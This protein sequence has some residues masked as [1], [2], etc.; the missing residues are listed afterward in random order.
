MQ[1]NPWLSEGLCS[2]SGRVLFAVLATLAMAG[3]GD[4]APTA[5]APQTEPQ[6]PPP[7]EPQPPPPTEPQPSVKWSVSPTLN[8]FGENDGSLIESPRVSSVVPMSPSRT[9]TKALLFVSCGADKDML[10]GVGFNVVPDLEN[11]LSS[12]IYE[13]WMRV[14]GVDEHLLTT[15]GF[16]IGWRVL[17]PPGLPIMAF[18]DEDRVIERLLKAIDTLAISMRWREEGR[19]AFRWPVDGAKEAIAANC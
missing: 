7:T 14:D 8:E 9:D 19:V 1:F 10:V 12:G 16:D 3:C 17:L 13:V 2:M 6:P 11:A 5:P 18:I 15:E 4:D